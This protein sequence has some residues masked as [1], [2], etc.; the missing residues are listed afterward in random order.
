MESAMFFTFIGIVLLFLTL[1]F[2]LLLDYFSQKSN[3]SRN[4]II[5]RVIYT[6]MLVLLLYTFRFPL[7]LS[8]CMILT[9]NE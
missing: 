6:F 5:I 1:P 4:K 3:S 8:T 2:Y 9:N 7:Y